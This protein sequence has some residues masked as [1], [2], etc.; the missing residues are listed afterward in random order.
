VRI[1]FMNWLGR[2]LDSAA[3]PAMAFLV[4]CIWSICWSIRYVL[5]EAVLPRP[6]AAGNH[7]SPTSNLSGGAPCLGRHDGRGG[8][9]QHALREVTLISPTHISWV[10]LLVICAFLTTLGLLLS[11]AG[12]RR[13]GIRRPE[14]AANVVHRDQSGELPIP[15][16][17]PSADGQN[18]ALGRDRAHRLGG[19]HHQ[20]DDHLL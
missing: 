12:I 8:D 10:N 18:P 16:R 9:S 3:L 14:S 6:P 2:P 5:R 19:V 7:E 20:I 1:H 11:Y 17:R 4:A 15:L 13:V